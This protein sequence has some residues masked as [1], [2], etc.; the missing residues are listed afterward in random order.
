MSL[1]PG[2]VGVYLDSNTCL[3]HFEN[4]KHHHHCRQ[5]QSYFFEPNNLEQ[6]ID[7]D[8]DVKFS[9]FH[10][11]FSNDTGWIDRLDQSCTVSDQ[12]FVFCSELHQHTVD[13]LI[14]LDRPGILM[15]ICGFINYEFKHAKIYTWMDWFI[16]TVYFYSIVRPNLLNEKLL[17]P[18]GKSKH[19]DI[20]LGCRRLHRDV[21]Y[22]YMQDN[23]LSD[24]VIMTY[25]QRWNIDLRETDHIFE[26]E[27]LEFLSESNYT[28]S[29]HQVQYYGYQMN[30]SQVVPFVIYNDSYYSVVAETNAV[31]EF[32]FYTE[33]IVKPILGKRLFVVIAGQGYL[34]RLRSFG[35]KTFDAVIDETYDLEPDH[36]KRWGMAMDQVRLLTEQDPV[37]IYAKIKDV[38]EHNQRLMLDTDWYGN[39]SKQLAAVIASY[40]DSVH[41]TA[42]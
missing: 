20:L 4:L 21:V 9:A 31:N 17:P 2:G 10:V 1:S 30:L 5:P 13:Q 24:K 40:L 42:D 26:S 37:E 19:F 3:Y 18:I 28:H 27:G 22:Q 39:F 7:S 38:V 29:G 34:Q 6:F 11:P 16:T 14:K 32:N 33:K 36:T 23:Q 35:F 12:I 41:T 15:F 25:Y 8:H